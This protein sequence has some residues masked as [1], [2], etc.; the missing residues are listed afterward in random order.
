MIE[1]RE[2]LEKELASARS[3]D[4]IYV[5]DQVTGDWSGYNLG[6]DT[7]VPEVDTGVPSDRLRAILQKLGKT[8]EEIV[9][10]RR[11]VR[12]LGQRTEMADGKRPVNWAGAEALALG[13]LL[14]EGFRV[15]VDGPGL[16]A[17]HVRPQARCSARCRNGIPVRFAPAPLPTPG[18]VRDSQ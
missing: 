14:L 8:P 18:Y 2:H 10:N 9:P 1:R 3:K 13:S 7:Q 16:R 17:R 5:G 4:Y 11:I 12:L 15:R 6:A